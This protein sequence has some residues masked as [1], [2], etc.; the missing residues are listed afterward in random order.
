MT[1]YKA[2][3]QFSLYRQTVSQIYRFFV[4]LLQTASMYFLFEQRFFFTIQNDG[5]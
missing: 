3:V 5:V 2:L 4:L 1:E